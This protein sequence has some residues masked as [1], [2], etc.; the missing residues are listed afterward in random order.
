MNVEQT[1]AASKATGKLSSRA[2]QFATVSDETFDQIIFDARRKL[3]L[4]VAKSLNQA[5]ARRGSLA[6]QA[7]GISLAHVSAGALETLGRLCSLIAGEA[8]APASTTPVRNIISEQRFA[9][10]LRVA[11]SRSD[12]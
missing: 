5:P 2:Q 3:S 6:Y 8:R 1:P 10:L 4:A 7:G 9:E 11:S 12:A